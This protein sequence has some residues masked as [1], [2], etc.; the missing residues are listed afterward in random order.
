LLAELRGRDIQIWADGDRLRCNAPAEVLTPELRDQLRQRKHDILEFLRSADVLAGQQRAIVPLQPRGTRIPVFAV[1]G[2]NGDVFCYRTL[3]QHLGDDQPLYGLEPPGLDGHSDPLTRI[4]DHA[5]YFAA[6]I[7]AFRPAGPYIIAGF[8]TGGTIAF[9]LGRHLLQE[10]AAIRFLAL[11]G[12]PYPTS[13]RLL[14]QLRQRLRDQVGRMVKHTRA[15]ASLSSGER[16]LYIA[17]KLR[18]RRLQRAAERAAPDSVLVLRAKVELAT[19]AA[20]RRYSPGHFAGRISLFVPC[21]D[22]A[23]SANEAL[24][25]QSVAQHVE[26][27]FGPDGCSSD[28]MLREPYG[29]AFA[30]L[31]KQCCARSAN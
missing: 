18:D 6:Q 14:P 1:A 26:Q 25:W 30:E 29:P 4:E 24:R 31:F 8:C 23:R 17:E 7:R 20:A 16:R 2:H 22:W 3:A 21:K 11:F 12:A 27:Y 15:L 28:T 9:E 19:I 10:R 5:A 13:Y